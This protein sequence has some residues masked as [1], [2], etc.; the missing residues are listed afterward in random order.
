[1]EKKPIKVLFGTMTG[2][3]E[4]LAER[5]AETLKEKG[6]EVTLDSLDG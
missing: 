6:H 4:D 1:M 3:A 2:N 5:A